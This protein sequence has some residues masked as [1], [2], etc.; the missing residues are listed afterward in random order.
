MATDSQAELMDTEAL[1]RKYR[2]ER[3]KR[4]RNDT[5]QQFEM[6][7]GE[8]V[9][10]SADPYIDQPLVRDAIAEEVDVLI[11]G[12]GFGGLLTGADLSKR[13]IT[14]FRIIDQAGDFGGTWYWNRYP[15]VRCDIESYLYMPLLED[16]GTIPTERYATGDEI[17]AHCQKIGEKFGLYDRALF[18]TTV[19][20]MVWDER[21]MRWHVTTDRNDLIKARFVTVSQGPLAKVKLPSVP[22][23]KDFKG[24]LSH[25]SRWDYDYTGGNMHGDLD[26]LRDKKVAVIGT[27]ATGIQLVPKVAQD[28]EHLYVIQ[29]TPSAVG[30]RNNR[31]TDMD[32][33]TSQK[34]GWQQERLDNFLGTITGA[35]A[36]KDAI[37]DCWTDFYARVGQGMGEAKAK[38]GTVNPGDVRQAVDYTKMNET[39]ALVD[40]I[41]DDPAT[42]EA[43]KP[44]Y[45]F[46]CKRPLFSDDFIESF[47]RDNVT[48][49]NT[50]GRGLER[51]TENGLVV[52]GK[53][54]AV[55]KI[56][57]ATGFDV[58]AA[59]Y[60]VGGYDV[61]GRG[62]VSMKDR[63]A[64]GVKTVHGTQSAHFPNFHIVGGVAQ[65][66]IAF[67][68]THTLRMQSEHA[69]DMIAMCLREGIGALE[70]TEDAEERWV[71]TLETNHHD[72]SKFQ[73]ECTPG[74]L[75][76]EGN[77]KDKP[78]FIGATFGAGP[79]AYNKLICE[80]RQSGW[81]GDVDLTYV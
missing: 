14:D 4:L 80:W 52:N 59:A 36:D 51:L 28:A 73:E 65:G 58:G 18:Q 24:K 70:V 26:G 15:G 77:M 34:P 5:D 42:A 56:V 3:D 76:N 67:N 69:A 1:S 47:N 60:A 10:L 17:F 78:T 35:A 45:N 8:Y 74:F 11:V 61:I 46:L 71:K 22:G 39:R 16:V 66:T 2:E 19:K 40:S 29:R 41:I 81:K 49:V 12:G 54:Y 57:F 79:I 55:D 48:L 23:M 62:G 37:K 43:L 31:P 44:W 25:S 64:D 7:A 75:N 20:K 13:G 72:L 6:N 32:W 68:F 21:D 53:E 63:F 38:G 30:R 27:G 50:E 9:D 33:Y